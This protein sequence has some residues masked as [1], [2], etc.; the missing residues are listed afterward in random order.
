MGKG[1]DKKFKDQGHANLHNP[2]NRMEK[3]FGKNRW[4]EA[5]KLNANSFI[6]PPVASPYASVSIRPNL[7]AFAPTCVPAPCGSYVAAQGINS[8]SVYQLGGYIFLCNGQTKPECFRFRVFGLPA[9]RIEVVEK[10]KP[11]MKLFLFDFSLK[12]LYGIYVAASSGG[13]GLE[14]A[15]FGGKFPAQVRFEILGDCLPLPESA[16]KHIIKDNYNGASKFRQEVSSEQVNKLVSLFH[17]ITASPITPQLPNVVSLPPNIEEEAESPGLHPLGDQYVARTQ[18]IKTEGA[19]KFQDVQL[20]AP[21]SSYDPRSLER[22]LVFARRAAES[23]HHLRVGSLPYCDPCYSEAYQTVLPQEK[24]YGRYPSV[25]AKSRQA[26]VPQYGSA[27]KHAN[28]NLAVAATDAR[29]QYTPRS[30][31][32]QDPSYVS[33]TSM[34]PKFPSSSKM[35]VYWTTEDTNAASIPYQGQASGNYNQRQVTNGE[36]EIVP[37]SVSARYFNHKLAA[38]A[39]DAAGRTHARAQLQPQ[40][41]AY[42]LPAFQRQVLSVVPTNLPSSSLKNTYWNAV[43]SMDPNYTHSSHH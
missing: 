21:H 11:N 23:L 18:L 16:F 19:P 35:A 42:D 22:C 36:G 41:Q 7:P 20:A 4:E 37:P 29:V 32:P 24:S 10:I 27:N 17:P 6:A 39:A 28:H 34:P 33:A 5:V 14:P 2:N 1:R 31:L 30:L 40:T 13:L 8:A 15:A 38:A 43:A 12:L 25:L 26:I 3:R 9:T